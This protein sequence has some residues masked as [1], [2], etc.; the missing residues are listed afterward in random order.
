MAVPAAASG[1]GGC[2][3]VLCGYSA[4]RAV[5][6]EDHALCDRCHRA[7]HVGQQK[8]AGASPDDAVQCPASGCSYRVAPPPDAKS[9][10]R[11]A[12]IGKDSAEYSTAT[13]GFE[14]TVGRRV[15]IQRVF[16]V[17]NPTLAD[18]FE[19]CRARLRHEQRDT[20]EKLMFHGTTRAAAGSIARSGFDIRYSGSHAEA[21]GPGAYFAVNASYSDGFTDADYKGARS[22]IV[23]RVLPGRSPGAGA[24]AAAR[25]AQQAEG[26]NYYDSNI[27]GSILAVR[28]EQQALPVYVIYYA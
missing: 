10:I 18:M 20:T 23:A 6:P 21:L 26:P 2:Q 9:Q 5:C 14:K 13:A 3:C 12:P 1:A 16:R 8:G 24:A 11:L 28:R 27:K 15:L 4:E 19:L 22:M 7:Y 25:G 17:H